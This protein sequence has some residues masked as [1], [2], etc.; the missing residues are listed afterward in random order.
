MIFIGISGE[1]RSSRDVD[2]ESENES[3]NSVDEDETKADEDDTK[4]DEDVSMDKYT[5]VEYPWH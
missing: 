1:K 5:Q 4:G 2:L 3:L